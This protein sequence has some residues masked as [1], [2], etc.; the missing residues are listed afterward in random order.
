MQEL[1][2]EVLVRI[3]TEPRNAV[4][5]QFQKLFEMEEV[6]LEIEPDALHAIAQAAIKR[7]TGAR[8]LRSIIEQS[9]LSTM[10]ELPSTNNVEKVVLNKSV[11]TGE[12]EPILHF[13]D[14]T[15]ATLDKASQGVS[16]AAA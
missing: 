7:K 15:T 8:G 1:D 12:S 9:L 6:E 14:G 10:Y 4:V 11:I 2:E 16:G 13:K 5:K 3:L